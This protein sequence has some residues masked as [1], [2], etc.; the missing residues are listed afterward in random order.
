MAKHRYKYTD[1]Q[2][3]HF[4]ALDLELKHGNVVGSEF[5]IKHPNFDAVTQTKKGDAKA[6]K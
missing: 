6:S 5:V 3:V 4:P 2:P 1:T